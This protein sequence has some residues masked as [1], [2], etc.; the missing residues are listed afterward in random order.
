MR[1]LPQRRR[2]AEP[3]T[4]EA[5]EGT[6]RPV[7]PRPVPPR[8]RSGC[9]C[10]TASGRAEPRPWPRACT[11]TA[12]SSRTPSW[13]SSRTDGEAAEAPFVVPALEPDDEPT[14]VPAL[15]SEPE[16]QWAAE[17]A[18]PGVEEV[19]WADI[20]Q[21]LDNQSWASPVGAVADDS[22]YAPSDDAGDETPWPP[23][24][25]EPVRAGRCR[26]AGRVVSP[27]F[28]SMPRRRSRRSR[29]LGSPPA[30]RRGGSRPPRPTSRPSCRVA[31]L[32][33]RPT[34]RASAVVCS[35]GGRRL[36][37]RPRRRSRR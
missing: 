7:A 16:E 2:A 32:R 13:T 4:P 21:A 18:V 17:S 26:A 20:P 35:T 1:K 30:A 9:R 25:P 19:G 37:R 33:R 36:S 14:I 24:A 27:S 22:A 29:F 23:V 5:R 28:R 6:Q 11:W 31:L 15:E 12:T 34:R 10:S 8:L 3:A